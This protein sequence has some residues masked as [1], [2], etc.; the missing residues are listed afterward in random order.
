LLVF[1]DTIFFREDRLQKPKYGPLGGTSESSMRKESAVVMVKE[2]ERYRD[3]ETGKIFTVKAVEK[4]EVL[5]VGENGRG[6]R[7]TSVRSLM[8]AC[9][10]LEERENPQ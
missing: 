4:S 10:K 8:Q 2:G 3:K 9:E 6:R 7:L 5:L 1:N